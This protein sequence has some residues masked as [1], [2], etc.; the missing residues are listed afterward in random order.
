[1]LSMRVCY[2]RTLV[3]ELISRFYNYMGCLKGIKSIVPMCVR[4][5]SVFANEF[6]AY[7]KV[8]YSTL[9]IEAKSM[10]V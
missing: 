4:I 7:F 6:F 8:T 3:V 5:N 9:L 10:H 2:A 1:M